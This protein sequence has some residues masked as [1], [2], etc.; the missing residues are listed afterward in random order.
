MAFASAGP[1]KWSELNVAYGFNS[2]ATFSFSNI[3]ASTEGAAYTNVSLSNIQNKAIPYAGYLSR[4]KLAE[5]T[6][7]FNDNATGNTIFAN[8]KGVITYVNNTS[9]PGEEYFCCEWNGFIKLTESGTHWFYMNSDDGSE[10]YINNSFAAAWYGLHGTGAGPSNSI[11]LNAGVYPM[12]IRFQ[13]WGGGELCEVNYKAPSA[14]VFSTL[15]VSSQTVYA[16][17]PYIKLDANDLAY[18]QGQAANSAIATWSNMGTDGTAVHASGA[19]GNSSGNPTLTSDING[20]MVSFNRTNQQ[21]F[22]FNSSL[23]FDKFRSADSLD[24]NGLTVLCVARFSPSSPGNYERIFDIGNGA[25]N[26]NLVIS[27]FGTQNQFAIMTFNGTSAIGT[28]RYLSYSQIDGAFHVYAICVANG[29]PTTVSLVIDGNQVTDG[30]NNIGGWTQTNIS[31]NRT[32]NTGYV[33]RSASA[34]D[35]YFTGDI[36]ELHIYKEVIPTSMMIQMSKYLM[37]KWGVRNDT[38]FIFNGLVGYFTG[39]SW[40]GSVWN[41]ISP[42]GNNSSAVTG[43]PVN[44]SVTLNGFKCMSGG[45]T[46]G[47]RFPAGMLVSG[48]TLFHVAKYNGSTQKRIFDDYQGGSI[49]WLSGFWEG[50]SGVAYHN[51]WI[52][53]T[54]GVHGSNWV[55]S[56]DQKDLYKSNGTQRSSTTGSTTSVSL[57]INYGNFTGERSDWAVACIIAYNRTLTSTEIQQMELYLNRKYAIY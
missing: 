47:I 29:N 17:K 23:V 30:I 45:T 27:R 20:Y 49:N 52:T 6:T 46:A 43:S 13:E 51:G 21:Y 28:G 22:S 39:E 14:S 8:T 32:L 24:I 56:V 33:G 10:L 36:R 44:N 34:A 57:S 5:S 11:S 42:S 40:T 37:M 31:S 18:R 7:N 38:A 4:R 48:Y 55:L 50:Q 15:N 54:S 25:P 12:R 41:D 9:V 19:S 3:R 16:F 35:A 53:G 26:D 1:I 2:N